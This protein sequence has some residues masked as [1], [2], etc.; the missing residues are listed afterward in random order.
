MP[1]ALILICFA[2][3]VGATIAYWPDIYYDG[4]GIATTAYCSSWASG[5]TADYRDHTEIAA[6]NISGGTSYFAPIVYDMDGD[7]HR[8]AY[9]IYGAYLQVYNHSLNLL[10]ELSTSV[11]LTVQPLVA[12]SSTKYLV[13]GSESG[14]KNYMVK[15]DWN[16][17]VLSEVCKVNYSVVDAG[18]TQRYIVNCLGDMCVGVTSNNGAN[19]FQGAYINMS[20]C[21]IVSRATAGAYRAADMGQ[22]AH[23][24]IRDID[25][26]GLIEVAIPFDN[27][28][29]N[30]MGFM[31]FQVNQ[32]PWIEDIDKD[33]LTSASDY[34]SQ[35]MLYNLDGAGDVE[36]I[37]AFD[38]VKNDLQ[39][40][41][42]KTDLTNFMGFPKNYSGW[43]LNSVSNLALVS[44]VNLWVCALGMDAQ[45][46]N[47]SALLCVTSD[48]ATK[49][50]AWL[51]SPRLAVPGGP[52]DYMNLIAADLDNDGSSELLMPRGV[53]DGPYANYEDGSIYNF[54]GT[55]A[56][57][58][59]VADFDDDDLGDV[60]LQG[61]GFLKV[62][63]GGG[64]TASALLCY[65]QDS[66]LIGSM[67]R[68]TGNPVCTGQ[69][70]TYSISVTDDDSTNV[71]LLTDCNGDGTTDITGAWTYNV[72]GAWTLT[73][74]CQYNTTGSFLP[75]FIVR[76]D[77]LSTDSDTLTTSVQ[78]SSCYNSGEGGGSASSSGSTPA[79]SGNDVDSFFGGIESA[80]G[81]SKL[82]LW[83]IFMFG[84]GIAVVMAALKGGWGGSAMSMMLL[85][86][87]G[88]LVVLG[89]I[90]GFIGVGIVI[91][92]A[93]LCLVAL[94]IWA[95]DAFGG[96]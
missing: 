47:G 59:A 35:P 25:R 3:S 18:A 19:H 67:Y 26:D 4:A 12:G 91:I 27:N 31:V 64:L 52:G 65:Y 69:S 39:I 32:T 70:V 30:V 9:V 43:T 85:F 5:I 93:L 6:K 84:C 17:S 83:V 62:Y 45:E 81:M 77:C 78:A 92:L 51:N 48:G 89:A 33:D 73:A 61:N 10:D 36:I 11:A 71:S 87:E 68:D 29:N 41:A 46:V 40:Q 79:G 66:P 14:G 38:N 34:I 72:L 22:H 63:Y 76:D 74:S 23:P 50:P 21:V 24:A 96:V 2:A 16:G 8:E 57:K 44:D 13:A 20:S 94:V 75:S 80:T 95:K 54:S 58:V 49:R 15:F 55:E 28:M 7:G 37:V 56:T 53:I 1:A 60:L 86:T 82:V 88:G 90:F 42:F